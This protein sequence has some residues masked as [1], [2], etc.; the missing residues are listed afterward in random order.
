MW[1]VLERC[2][3]SEK[4]LNIIMSMYV[5]TKG[6]Y[7]LGEIETDWVKSVNRVRQGCIL[8][9]LQFGLYTEE[10]AVGVNKCKFATRV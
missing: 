6:K 10:L 1:K 3:I 2:G 8:S 9:P 7:A 5:N 4:V